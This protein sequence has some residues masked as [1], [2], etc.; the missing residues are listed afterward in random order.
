MKNWHEKYKPF[1]VERTTTLFG[2]MDLRLDY[3]AKKLEAYCMGNIET[4]EELD[5]DIAE[6]INKTW[7][8]PVD[9]AWN[10]V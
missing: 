6:G 4:I 9:Y 3:A 10:K 2:G 7:R 5:E 1:G 8:R